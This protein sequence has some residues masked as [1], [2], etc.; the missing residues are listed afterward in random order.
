[1]AVHIN[2][3]FVA[4]SAAA[5][6]LPSNPSQNQRPASQIYSLAFSEPLPQLAP[7]L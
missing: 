6:L 1:M 2:T 4:F 3:L 7:V 5:A